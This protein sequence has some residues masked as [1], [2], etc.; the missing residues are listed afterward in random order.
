MNGLNWDQINEF[1]NSDKDV[2]TDNNFVIEHTFP[3]SW[4][5]YYQDQITIA[6]DNRLSQ[7]DKTLNI[8]WVVCV[9]EGQLKDLFKTPLL[10][11]V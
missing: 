7:T 2:A 9:A 6:T 11:W 4:I 8:L 3:F 10:I 5:Q 1:S